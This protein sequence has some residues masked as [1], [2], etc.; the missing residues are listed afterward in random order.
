MGQGK[1]FIS[2]ISLEQQFN[3]KLE[4]NENV[5]FLRNPQPET[6][7]RDSLSNPLSKC[8]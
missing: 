1:P 7:Q 6:E 4:M 8:S 3:V 5:I 2:L